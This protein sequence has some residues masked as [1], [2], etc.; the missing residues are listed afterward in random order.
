[1]LARSST[2]RGIRSLAAKQE[3]FEESI[4]LKN[5][6]R[7]LDDDEADFLQSVLA[8]DRAKE[9]EAK[10]ADT[11]QLEVF[12]AQ[13][14]AAEKALKQSPPDDEARPHET[15]TAGSRKRKKQD[16]LGGLK[17]RQQTLETNVA[18]AESTTVAA[19]SPGAAGDSNGRATGERSTA[20]DAV[21]A[22]PGLGLADYSS[23]DE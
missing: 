7:T 20:T 13:R 22:K 8:A 21:T 4:R 23:D 12:R 6:F 18:V 10:K 15:W 16:L 1:M 9:A 11:E 3:A 19:A 2:D 17:K 14:E 5:Q